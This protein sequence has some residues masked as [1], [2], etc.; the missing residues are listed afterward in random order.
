MSPRFVLFTDLRKHQL[1]VYGA[2]LLT[3]TALIH[4]LTI[5]WVYHI[6][7]TQKS[8]WSHRLFHW[9]HLSILW[10]NLAVHKLVELQASIGDCHVN[11]WALLFFSELNC[12]KRHYTYLLCFYSLLLLLNTLLDIPGLTL[13]NLRLITAYGSCTIFLHYGLVGPTR[14][15]KLE[16]ALETLMELLAFL[17]LLTCC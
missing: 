3:I 5:L 7:R 15:L 11:H 6:F 10:W 9:I 17:C 4:I 14:E 12:S 16:L 1:Q 2:Y 13:I 8:S